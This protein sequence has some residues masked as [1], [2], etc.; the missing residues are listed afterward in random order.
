[1]TYQATPRA[2]LSPPTPASLRIDAVAWIAPV[3]VTDDSVDA[4]EVLE[5]QLTA[6][7]LRYVDEGGWFREVRPPPGL[8]GPDDLVLEFE[9]QRLFY[10]R[11]RPASVLQGGLLEKME[12]DVHFSGRLAARDAGGL[13]IAEVEQKLDRP[14]QFRGQPFGE[15]K[16]TTRAMAARTLLVRS[17][18]QSLCLILETQQR[19][20]P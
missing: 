20:T 2:T 4:K 18:L 19:S 10:Q 15:K 6:S 8:L 13:I 7:I 5:D 16:L 11:H 9:F 3:S 14:D 1:M 17:L 12:D